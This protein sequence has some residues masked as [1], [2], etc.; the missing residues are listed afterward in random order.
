MGLQ[1]D[2]FLLSCLKDGLRLDRRDFIQH[3]DPEFFF[4]GN[5]GE[6]EVT[7][8]KTRILA[9]V[10]TIISSPKISKPSDG[11]IS[12]KVHFPL[13]QSHSKRAKFFDRNNEFTRLIERGICDS[14]AINTRALCIQATKY[15][16][17]LEVELTVIEDDGGIVDTALLAAFTAILHYRKP[18]TRIVGNSLQTLDNEAGVPLTL[19]SVPI[20]TTYALFS[21][22]DVIVADPTFEEEE[23]ADGIFTVI[24]S[25]R[26]KI[27]GTNKCGGA[28]LP[29][30]R[31]T[32]LTT[33]ALHQAKKL[34]TSIQ[35]QTRNAIR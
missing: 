34:H 15:V 7:R 28:P 17:N 32:Q 22:I 8:G 4:S 27:C 29:P 9:R 2:N 24:S 23:N 12:V 30:N 31:L 35:Y 33:S 16:W 18:K 21:N 10:I 20:S 3:R 6:V 14:H 5:N 26:G 19:T 11:A 1:S 25:S 13:E